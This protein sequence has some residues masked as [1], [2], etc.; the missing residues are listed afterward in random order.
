MK[1]YV[2]LY[3]DEKNLLQFC[4][5]NKIS[6]QNTSLLIQI[7]TAFNNEFYIQTLLDEVKSLLPNAVIIG[8]TTDGEIANGKV[9]TQKTIINFTLFE[10][11]KLNCGLFDTSIDSYENGQNLAKTLVEK[12]TKLMIVFTDGLHTN[13][14]KLLNCINNVDSSVKVAGGMAGDYSTFTKTLVFPKDKII[15]KGAVAVSLN[16]QK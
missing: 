16:T 1:N 2:L 8:S 3:T 5:E 6:S 7:F 14:E 12:D 9:H 4:K 10:H 13:G 11:T 15:S